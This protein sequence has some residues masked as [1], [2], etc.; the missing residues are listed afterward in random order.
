M[1]K[2]TIQEIAKIL[3]EKNK[4]TP[5]EASQFA[6]SMFELIQQRLDSEELVKIKGLGTFKMIRVEARESV[7]VRTGERVMIDSHAK[8]TFTPDTMMKE[9]VN[10]PF[11]QFETVVLNDGIE[12][13][14]LADDLTEEEQMDQDQENEESTIAQP[15]LDVVENH[16]AMEGEKVS[17][18]EE[19]LQEE[20]QTEKP[21]MEVPQPEEP[22]PEG[23]L[24]FYEEEEES[25][26]W[27]KTLG[28]ALLTL[29]LM[30]ASAYGGYWYGQRTAN[31]VSEGPVTETPEVTAV[32]SIP[33]LTNDTIAIAEEPVAEQSKQ[34]VRQEQKAEEEPFWKKYEAMDARV[35][36][37]AYH[38]VGTDHEVKA[39]KGET[40]SRIARHELGEGMSCYIEVYNDLKPNTPLQ[41]GQIIKI[42]KLKWKKRRSNN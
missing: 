26:S 29:L 8:I 11:S 16:P 3:V 24:S 6:V 9:L 13:E 17:V 37:G 23:V 34:E 40:L 20:P 21:Q 39:R 12:F 42:P 4:L 15:L 33:D 31:A 28:Y 36:T 35:R 18:A 25:L 38:I 2:L 5:K 14:D 19:P 41:E 30:A 32:D 22:Q 27:K 7:S 10:K 1:G